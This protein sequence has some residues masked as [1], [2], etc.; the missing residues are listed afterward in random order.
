MFGVIKGFLGGGMMAKV[1]AGGIAFLLVALLVVFKL[2]LSSHEARGALRAEVFE[3]EGINNRQAAVVDRLEANTAD[4]LVQIKQEHARAQAATD[5][6]VASQA[7]LETA[8]GDFED[9]LAT[10]RA[11]LTNE[12]LV[13]AEQSVPD[14]YIDSL[15]ERSRSP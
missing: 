4:L 2:L 3:A 5:A 1:M 14:A 12:E 9:R 15:R 6:L 13:C 8:K 10:A 11:E 7:G